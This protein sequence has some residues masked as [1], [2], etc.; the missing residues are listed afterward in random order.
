MDLNTTQQILVVVLASA[1]A[2]FLVLS[3]VAVA[4][5]IRLLA[6]LRMVANKAERIVESVE[7]IGDA[8][9][10]TAGP[11]GIF[12]FVKSMVDVVHNHGQDKQK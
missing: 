9:K 1:L 3:I 11:L 2:I 5:V 10:K 6:T 7:S 4:L 8:F 12:R